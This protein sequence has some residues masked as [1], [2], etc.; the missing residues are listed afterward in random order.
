MDSE[1]FTALSE[2]IALRIRELGL[3][4]PV[5]LRSQSLFVHTSL[6]TNSAESPLFRI[7]YSDLSDIYGLIL[8][9]A[10][11]AEYIP[12]VKEKNIAGLFRY[13]AHVFHTF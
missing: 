8:S 6:V 13:I 1:R 7:N 9:S 12:Q 3:L 5:S 4:A 10:V 2:R 11:H